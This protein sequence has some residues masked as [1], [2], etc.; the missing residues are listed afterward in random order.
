MEERKIPGAVYDQ[1]TK[2]KIL[3][4]ATE[5]FALKGFNAVSMREIANAVGIKMSSIYHYYDGKDSL[6]KDV[7]SHFETGYRHYFDWLTEVNKKADSLETLMD[8]F[9]NKEFL[10][11]RNPI[12]C[13]AMSLIL[14]EQH[15]NES[16][17][18]CV[19]KLIYEFSINRIQADIDR[20]VAKGKIPASDTKTAST[21]FM[22]GVV[23]SNDLRIHEHAGTKLPI[24]IMDIYNG[25]R[26]M[27]TL[28]LS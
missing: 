7:L 25:I 1:D 24:E 5:L 22:L 18:E 11:M 2:N 3:N 10:E 14:K 6:L 16:A 9:F 13:F 17:R 28:A 26:K 8:N 19:L 15:N 23:I 4:T 20:L 27:L 12:A 21:L